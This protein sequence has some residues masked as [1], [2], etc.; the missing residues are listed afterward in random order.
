MWM[1]YSSMHVLLLAL[2]A[3]PIAL[4]EDEPNL[5]IEDTLLLW[6]KL[7]IKVFVIVLFVNRLQDRQA[8]GC[9]MKNGEWG[10]QLRSNFDATCCLATATFS[11]VQYWKTD[12]ESRPTWNYFLF[13][14][15]CNTT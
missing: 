2:F 15:P 9:P 13:I 6:Q 11:T 12:G 5:K 3:A 7:T 8:L 1:K 10:F 4:P 14:Q